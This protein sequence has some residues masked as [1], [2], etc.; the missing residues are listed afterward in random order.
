M[1]ELQHRRR[2]IHSPR[3]SHIRSKHRP[4]I[5]TSVIENPVSVTP[6]RTQD[7]HLVSPFETNASSNGV[8]GNIPSLPIEA[9]PLN[10]LWVGY[11]RNSST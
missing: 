7:A 3:S 6:H 10:Q 5:D 1:D 11:L 2:A 9:I 8:K 4:E